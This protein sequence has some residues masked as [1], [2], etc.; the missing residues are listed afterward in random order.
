MPGHHTSTSTFCVENIFHEMSTIRPVCYNDDRCVRKKNRLLLCSLCLVGFS[1]SEYNYCCG[2][3][4][5]VKSWGKA[6]NTDK[7]AGVHHYR[8]RA[9]AEI[10]CDIP[11]LLPPPRPPSGGSVCADP[12]GEANLDRFLLNVV[13]GPD[14]NPL[15]ASSSVL[16]TD[17]SILPSSLRIQRVLAQ[18]S[19]MSYMEKGGVQGSEN[20]CGNITARVGM[21]ESC[22]FTKLSVSRLECLLAMLSAKHPLGSLSRSVST[23]RRRDALFSTPKY[24][25]F[26]RLPRIQRPLP[27]LREPFLSRSSWHCAYFIIGC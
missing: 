4:V 17:L 15:E 8:L 10:E 16:E 19:F 1:L 2:E 5:P 25:A 22:S 12:D 14:P 9:G 21:V 11:P 18:A 23:Y 27:R 13:P 26:Y 3:D 24:T 6:N 20:G 7:K